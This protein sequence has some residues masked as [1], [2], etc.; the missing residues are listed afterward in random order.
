MKLNMSSSPPLSD[1]MGPT[2]PLFPTSVDTTHKSSHMNNS[3]GGHLLT[4]TTAIMQNQ[5]QRKKITFFSI[6]QIL[7]TDKTS[8]KTETEDMQMKRTRGFGKHLYL[9]S[10]FFCKIPFLFF[11]T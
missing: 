5:Q 3:S 11:L 6:D 2:Q 1:Y 9:L 10:K 4:S 8:T 7:G